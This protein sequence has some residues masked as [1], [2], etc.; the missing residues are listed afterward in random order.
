MNKNKISETH[1]QQFFFFQKLFISRM[2]RCVHTH[3]EWGAFRLKANL[4]LPTPNFSWQRSRGRSVAQH[5]K[6]TI[7]Q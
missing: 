6:S 2:L 1:P 5:Y 3:I 7:R 4:Q